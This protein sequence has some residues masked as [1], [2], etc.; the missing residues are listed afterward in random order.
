MARIIRVNELSLI[1]HGSKLLV[2]VGGCFDLFHIGH[3]NFIKSAKTQ[4]SLLIVLLES[5]ETVKRLKGPNRP[6][7]T[8]PER[9]KI[10]SHI[11]LI[12][13]IITLPA[14]LKDRDYFS[15]I[16]TIQPDIIAVTKHDP[17][18]EKK[19]MQA[20]AVSAELVVIPKSQDASTSKIANILTREQI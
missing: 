4:N 16:K 6:I 20:A 13:Y 11:D 1:P 17:I 7:H 12:D 15:I 9:A 2:L 18:I 19:Q 14:N 8:Q 3:L 5:D 10:L